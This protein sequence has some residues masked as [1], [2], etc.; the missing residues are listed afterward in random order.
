MNDSCTRS[1]PLSTIVLAG[2]LAAAASA[3]SEPPVSAPDAEAVAQARQSLF[4][5]P[6]LP[7]N[8]PI[9]NAAGAAATFSTAGFIDLEN[10]FHEPQGTN[11]RSCESCH[12]PTAGWSVRPLD[13]EL[14][15]TLTDGTHPIF[16]VLDA[17]SPAADVTTREARYRSYSMLRAGLFRRSSN[18]AA[19]AEFEITAVDDPL[20]TGGTLTRFTFFRRP[21]ATANFLHARN[22]GWHD[23]NTNGSGDVTAG[24]DVQA[25]GNITG[26][27]QG[28][29]PAQAVVD[30]IVNYEKGLWFAQQISFA[31]GRLDRC[32][33]RGGP[34][35]L[36]S[37]PFVNGRFNLFDAWID[38][39]GC[40]ADPGRRKVARGQELFNARATAGGLTC[41]ACHNA[42]NS[43]SHVAGALF[44]I[45]TSAAARRL[46][47]MPLYTVRHKSTLEEIQTT[48]PGRA[49]AT[50]RWA[51]LNRFKVPSL[52]GLA[53][54]PPYFHN[55][56]AATLTDVI[57]LYEEEFGFDFSPGEESDLVAFMNAL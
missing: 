9:P 52:R 25:K 7:N 2:G 46:P 21:L 23:Q 3:C 34:Q 30:S 38:G 10:P 28:P 53:A 31:A 24:L 20:G 8:L 49:G 51:D 26:A 55:G 42:E 27:Q 16:N 56:V 6:R 43:G 57:H 44:N 39:H 17:N 37:Q 1:R 33:G 18:L 11:G 41:R 12:L 48:D 5:L 50:G 32:G 4:G 15:F 22:V 54:R 19:T 14:L 29:A 13:V 40:A 47:G 35:L 45:G 36:S